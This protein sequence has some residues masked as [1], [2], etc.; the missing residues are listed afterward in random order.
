M[1]RST[2]DICNNALG[3]VGGTRI[4]SLTED[5]ENARLCNVFYKPTVDEVLV[6]HN[7]GCAKHTKVITSDADFEA[8]DFDYSYEYRYSLPSNPYCLKIRK[9][10]DGEKEYAK[11]GRYIY[12]DEDECELVY[13]KRITD[14]NEFDPLLVDAIELQLAIKLS[15]PLQ[16][17][18]RLRNELIEYLEKVVLVRAKSI[19]AAERYKAP[20]TNKWQDAGR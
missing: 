8:D 2:T 5:S 15:F 9:F 10:N 4:S 7:W 17:T 20:S 19:D 13:T 18:N 14:T 11:Q 12:S 1:S 6:M 3:M 16:A